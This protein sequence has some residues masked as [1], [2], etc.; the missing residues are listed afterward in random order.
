MKL[1]CTHC[2]IEK[3]S[4]LFSKDKYKKT[5]HRSRCKECN[6]IDHLKRYT[7]DPEG[8]KE[9]SKNYR[10]RIKETNPEKLFIHNRKTKLKRDYNLTL[11]QYEI[12]LK[13]Q[14]GVCFLCNSL[15]NKKLLAVDHCHKTNKVRKLLCS[16]C[17]TALGLF[18]D[19]INVLN[20]AISYLKEN[21]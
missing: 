6:K 18:K 16:N 15:P 20:K 11:E 2:F 7:N 12:M 3:D 17:N 10:Q 4:S 1:I 13:E 5:G 21:Q 8:Q 19:D 14:N 9:R